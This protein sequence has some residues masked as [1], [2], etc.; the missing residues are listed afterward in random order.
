[1]DVDGG[2]A[3]VKELSSAGND[4]ANVHVVP[5]AGHHVYLDNPEETNRIIDEA[6]KALPRV[7]VASAATTSTTTKTSPAQA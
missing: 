7:S 2:H 6:I 3:S 4:R 5:K 1:M